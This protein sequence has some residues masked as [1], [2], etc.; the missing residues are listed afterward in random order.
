[1]KLYLGDTVIWEN[2]EEIGFVG[3]KARK[4]ALEQRICE[5]IDFMIAY[6]FIHPQHQPVLQ[7]ISRQKSVGGDTALANLYKA[8]R[9]LLESHTYAHAT[10]MQSLLH[11]ENLVVAVSTDPHTGVYVQLAQDGK[12]GQVLM[13]VG[14]KYSVERF[15]PVNQALET[16]LF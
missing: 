10:Y 15:S 7:S 12:G 2:P 5:R 16:K 1:M 6:P 3:I 13:T 9:E 8:T 14:Q 11:D 4:Q